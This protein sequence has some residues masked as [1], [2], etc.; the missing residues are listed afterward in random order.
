M[1]FYMPKG[2]VN[3]DDDGKVFEDKQE[4]KFQSKRAKDVKISLDYIRKNIANDKIK[5]VKQGKEMDI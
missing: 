3:Y 1:C 2:R 4:Q 5:N